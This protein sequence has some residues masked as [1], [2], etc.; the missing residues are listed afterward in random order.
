MPFKS[1]KQQRWMWANEPRI[2]REW[3]DRY[4][5]KG[6]GR[7]GY[8]D[9]LMAGFDIKE[10]IWE[11][12]RQ[13]FSNDMFGKDYEDLSPDQQETIDIQLQM[14]LGKKEMPQP[15][16][17]T[18]Q[19]GGLMD[20]ADQGGMKNYLGEQEMVS[21]PKQWRSGPDS[22]STE[23]AYITQPEKDMIMKA[24]IHG[25]LAEGP[26]EGPSGIISLDSQ[27]DYTRD[28]SRDK[29]RSQMSRGDQERE[30]RQEARMKDLLTGNL[31]AKD[32]LMHQTS[33]PGKLTRKYSD[34]PEW[35]E[36]KQPDGTYKRKHMASAYKSYG[37]PSFFGNLFSR[38]APGYRGIKGLPAWGD[39]MKNY[40]LRGTRNPVTRQI[41]PNEYGQMGYYTDKEN[42]GE[43]RDAFPA[44]GILGMLKSM[45][46]KFKK[47]PKDMSEFNKLSLTAPE[48][49]K[50]YI[51]EGDDV[52]MARRDRWT[53][54]IYGDMDYNEHYTM[55]SDAPGPWNNFNRPTSNLDKVTNLQTNIDWMGGMENTPSDLA[56]E[57]DRSGLA[58]H[59]D[60][61]SFYDFILEKSKEPDTG[62]VTSI[63]NNLSDMIVPVGINADQKKQILSDI[64]YGRDAA[65]A[66]R[67]AQDKDATKWMGLKKTD[68][69]I[70]PN[71]F[72]EL[73][74][75]QTGQP[76]SESDKLKILNQYT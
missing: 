14:E 46:N 74:E 35:M 2:A 41:T 72:I 76:M 32:S 51:P 70:R 71:E 26:N 44:F 67:A 9:G 40:Q 36:V 15:D 56:M 28:R 27:G 12:N 4:G 58:E 57:Y 30:N 43:T 13:R 23:L 19:E 65:A 60:G 6:G 47:P 63:N 62:G 3:T 5:A 37:T 33:A 42:F 18:A 16:R 31:S 55:G 59:S 54:P 52:P 38:G 7:I 73:W 17:A 39:P 29:D 11:S 45:A 48:D 8:Q 20:W 66:F 24:N 64:E 10:W 25:S 68:E 22:P 34:L 50:V 21:A 1:D 49:Q 61:M 53:D 69:H 75:K